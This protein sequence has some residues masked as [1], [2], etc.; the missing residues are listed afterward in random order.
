MDEELRSA[1][2]DGEKILWQGK[3]EKFVTL[4][5]TNKKAFATKAVITAV[6]CIG[7]IIA[8]GVATIPQ[9]MF[10][11]VLPLVV[12]AF[13]LLIAVSVFLDARRVR[14]MQYFITDQRLLWMTDSITGVPYEAIKEYL[15]SR[16]DDDHTSLLIGAEAVKKKS[17]RW[18]TLAA[19]PVSI[20]DTTGICEQ[21]VFYALPHAERAKKIFEEQLHKKG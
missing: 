14:K 5:K 20:N 3:P 18:R 15:F 11:P 2:N 4:D 1:L 9:G 6:I 16:D 19:S 21:A 17:S 7:L 8:Y 13:G 10:K 12:A